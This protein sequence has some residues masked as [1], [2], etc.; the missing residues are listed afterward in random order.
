MSMCM[1]SKV[2]TLERLLWRLHNY[3]QH[4]YQNDPIVLLMSMA[5]LT[6]LCISLLVFSEPPFMHIK[7]SFPPLVPFVPSTLG[8][9][10]IT[11]LTYVQASPCLIYS[12]FSLGIFRLVSTCAYIKHAVGVMAMT[13][14]VCICSFYGLE[15]KISGER[16][17]Y[18]LLF[19]RNEEDIL[20]QAK[21]KLTDLKCG[22]YICS[23]SRR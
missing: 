19:A 13:S 6:L 8:K 21:R 5:P 15:C 2:V 1:I 14:E 11:G 17:V 18:H 7:T 16:D 20:F 9:A 4:L 12:F 10:C 22:W 3:L 23:S